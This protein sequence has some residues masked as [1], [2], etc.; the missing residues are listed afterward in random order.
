ML[1]LIIATAVIA[2][3]SATIRIEE[4]RMARVHKECEETDWNDYYA[5]I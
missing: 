1:Q 2:G 4:T 3:I 5:N